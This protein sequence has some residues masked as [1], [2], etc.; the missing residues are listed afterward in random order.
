MIR[1]FLPCC[2]ENFL[3]DIE[4]MFLLTSLRSSCLL[5]DYAGAQQTQKWMLTVS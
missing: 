3:V 1:K 5:W 4:K 2:F